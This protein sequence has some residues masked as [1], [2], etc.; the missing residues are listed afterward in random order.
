LAPVL[1]ELLAFA[2]IFRVVPHRTVKWRHAFAGA[3]LSML[4][5]ELVKWGITRYIG[6]FGAYQKL[7]GPA[8]FVPR[9]PLGLSLGWVAS[10]LS[11]LWWIYLVWVSILLGASC[12]ASMSAFRYQPASMR[13]PEGYEIYGLL[14]LLGR[15][16]EYRRLG[17]GLHSDDIQKLEPLLTDELIQGFLAQLGEIGL[18]TRAESGEWLL[19]QI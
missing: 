4:L 6:S 10:L 1:I 15:F 18:V 2:T 3:V 5:F 12:A 9:L 11:F 7:Y 14:R 17:K 8:A 13:L 16:S 19:S